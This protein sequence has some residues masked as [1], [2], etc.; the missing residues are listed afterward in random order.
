M[1]GRGCCGTWSPFLPSPG[2]ATCSVYGNLHYL[3]FDGSHFTFMGKCT[4]IMSQTC[5][6]STGKVPEMHLQLGEGS[7]VRQ[8]DMGADGKGKG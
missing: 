7:E 3:T 1:G 5:G 8:L 2:T 6:N 4:Y